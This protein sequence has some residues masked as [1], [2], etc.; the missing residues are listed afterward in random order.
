MLW[1]R[2]P[3]LASVGQQFSGE[4]WLTTLP[5]IRRPNQASLGGDQV[6]HRGNIIGTGCPVPLTR[7][8]ET[9]L[10]APN[11]GMDLTDAQDEMVATILQLAGSI[12]L[13]FEKRD[14]RNALSGRGGE[15]HPIHR[16]DQ[17]GQYQGADKS[18]VE[19]PRSPR[20]FPDARTAA[21]STPWGDNKT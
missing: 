5:E 18:Q 1:S 3:R 14:G 21:R 4:V 12:L 10:V 17:R 7:G 2:Q 16:N 11:Y 8:A 6:L 13:D 20:T 15:G 19:R 9:T